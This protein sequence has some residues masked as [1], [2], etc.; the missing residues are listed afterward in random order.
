MRM[1]YACG[2]RSVVC[3]NV[4]KFFKQSWLATEKAGV[5]WCRS[6][7]EQQFALLLDVCGFVKT[8]SVGKIKIPYKDELGLNRTYF[9]DFLVDLFCGK[10]LLVELKGYDFGGRLSFKLKAARKLCKR[11]GFVFEMF[12]D[13][14]EAFAWVCSFAV[15]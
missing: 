15:G 4:H 3:G 13:A 1:L 14:L 11:S 12:E 2:F 5:I 9:P 6:S 7:Y 10:K 8:F